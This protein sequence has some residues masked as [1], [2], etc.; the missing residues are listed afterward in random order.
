MQ[1]PDHSNLSRRTAL[2]LGAAATA[3]GVASGTASADG[4][5]DEEEDDENDEAAITFRNQEAE[6]TDN[7]Q[8]EVTIDEVTLPDDGFVVV[9]PVQDEDGEFIGGGI[10][11][12][13]DPLGEGTSEDVTVEYD[14][15]E[16]PE[17]VTEDWLVAMP[18]V[19][20]DNDERGGSY[21]REGGPVIDVAHVG[22]EE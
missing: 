1:G 5:N 19:V 9:H 3:L 6:E 7:D 21:E 22:P 4:H 15:D 2:K 11:E 14:P 8:K 13:A 17:D 10:G 20:E 18:H 16:I 12:T